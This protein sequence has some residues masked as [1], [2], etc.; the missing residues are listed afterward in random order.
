MGSLKK[1]IIEKPDKTVEV[2]PLVGKSGTIYNPTYGI[3]IG[4]YPKFEKYQLTASLGQTPKQLFDSLKKTHEFF[5]ANKFG[6]AII[7]NANNMNP[8]ARIA[9][10]QPNPLLMLCTLFL[11]SKDE[12]LD[13]WDENLAQI[14][15]DDLSEYDVQDFFSF[16]ETIAPRCTTDLSEIFRTITEL[17]KKKK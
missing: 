2:I 9:D 13:S 12:D 8:V 11:V 14:K 7:N 4:R 16:A 1:F 17:E 10:E 6:D 5:N 15:L 3:S